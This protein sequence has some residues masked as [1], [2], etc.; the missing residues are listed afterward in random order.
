MSQPLS[1]SNFK[2]LTDKEMEELDVMIIPDDSSKGYILECDL[3]KY[4]FY[5]LY[6]NVYFIKC[7]VS[8]LCILEY[9]RDFI[10]CNVSFLCISECPH[11][12]HD[13]HKNYPLAPEHF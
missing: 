2:W 5:C 8:F 12:L 9:P 7:S 13:L 1:K 6:I 3:R 10:T 4:Y 11:E